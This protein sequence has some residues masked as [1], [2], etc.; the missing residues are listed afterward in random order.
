MYDGAKVVRLAQDQVGTREG[1]NEHNPYGAALGMD[2]MLW[3]SVFVSF[4]M[5]R[6]GFESLYPVTASTQVSFA[7]YKK[8]HWIIPRKDGRPGDI[9]W[10]FFPPRTGPVNHIGFV[11]KIHGDGSVSTIDGNSG[12]P[13]GGADG[14][15]RHKYLNSV[16]AVGRPGGRE[17]PEVPGPPPFPGRTLGRGDQGE[18]VKVVQRNLNRFLTVDIPVTGVF[19]AATERALVK[20][21]RNRLVP[22]ASLGHVGVG[23]WSMLAAPVF[24]GTL[25]QGSMGKGVQQLK[26]ALNRFGNDLDSNNPNFGPETRQVVEAWQKH[27]DQNVDGRVDMPTW[28]WMHIPLP[29]DQIHVPRL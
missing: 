14:V 3:C 27:R 22:A 25:A 8:Q 13:G 16:V 4:I 29:P 10:M 12:G 9:V 11:T 20:W 21:Q 19:D 2:N 28:Y 5:R 24:T 7:H 18:G 1:R 6:A 17:A 23:T 15:F 26:R